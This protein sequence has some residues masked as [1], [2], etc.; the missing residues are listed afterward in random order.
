[1]DIW[2][3]LMNICY[4]EHIINVLMHFLYPD[5]LYADLLYL[6]ML[7][8]DLLYPD[9][10]YPQCTTTASTADPD[11]GTTVA[12]DSLRPYLSLTNMKAIVS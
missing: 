10:L 8:P 11:F 7:Y 5:L 2:M 6:D 9:M 1:M 3:I 12:T 4:S